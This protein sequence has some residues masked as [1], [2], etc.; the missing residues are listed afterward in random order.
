MTTHRKPTAHEELERIESA[1]IDSLMNC[2]EQ[3]LREELAAAGGDPDVCIAEIEAAIAR[4][5]SE[6]VRRR[7][8][9]ARA[10]LAAW[11]EKTKAATGDKSEGARARF[12][13]MR[14][15]SDISPKMMLAARNGKNLS[16]RDLQSLLEDIAELERLE[17]GDE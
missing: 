9:A 7:M 5:Q 4:A 10:E 16:E 3:D 6:C 17:K 11:R 12:E 8:E 15:G 13:R 2:A 1:L 14:A